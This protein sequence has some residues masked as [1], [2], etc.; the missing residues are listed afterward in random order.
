VDGNSSELNL[1]VYFGI[2][3]I[4]SLASTITELVALKENNL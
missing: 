4:E 2:G 3:S 1:M